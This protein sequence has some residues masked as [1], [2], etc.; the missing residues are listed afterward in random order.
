MS[1]V[2]MCGWCGV[3][4]ATCRQAFPLKPRRSGEPW[5]ELGCDDCCG[6]CR[7]GSKDCCCI[8]VDGPDTTMNG[9]DSCVVA[10][11]AR[12]EL[13]Q[14]LESWAKEYYLEFDA[15][16]ASVRVAVLEKLEAMKEKKG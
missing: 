6:H 7:C 9:G 4:P 1:E 10:R 11:R 12:R 2:L 5:P 3:K 14:E 15:N 8:F 13:I 16:G